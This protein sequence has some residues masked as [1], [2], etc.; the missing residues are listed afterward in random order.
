MRVLFV[1]KEKN[2]D[3]LFVPVIRTR[4]SVHGAQLMSFGIHP[5][6][7]ISSTFIGLRKWWDG[8]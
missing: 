1:Y 6:L 4:L 8:M 5:G 2:G 7:M 3:N